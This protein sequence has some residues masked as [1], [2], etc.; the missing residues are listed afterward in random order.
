MHFL[1]QIPKE[2]IENDYVVGS[3]VGHCRHDDDH[4]HTVK[5][6]VYVNATIGYHICLESLPLIQ[7]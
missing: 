3:V 4:T 2:K 5:I 7:Q 6:Q 1:S